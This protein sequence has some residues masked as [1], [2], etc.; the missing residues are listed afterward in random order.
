M[1]R[2]QGAPDMA[3]E[4]KEA[5]DATRNNVFTFVLI[6]V[7]IRIAPYLVARVKQ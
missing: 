1:F 7:A 3:E 5:N 6:C 4:K 2:I